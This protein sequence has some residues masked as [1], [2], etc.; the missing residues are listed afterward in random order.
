M[1]IRKFIKQRNVA[2]LPKSVQEIIRNQQDEANSYELAAKEALEKSIAEAAFYVD[3]EHIEMRGGSAVSRINQALEYLV[4]HVYSE[5]GLVEKNAATDADVVEVLNS[6]YLPGAEPN[7]AAAAKV[8]E[9]LDLQQRMNLPTTMFDVQSRYQAAPYGWREIDVAAVVALLINQQKV[10]IKYGGAT[11]RSDDA[12]LPDMLRKKSEIGKTSISI[13]QS[14]KPQQMR[15]AREILREY[16]DVMD[17]PDDEEGLVRFII[18][19]FS[20]QK[21]HYQALEKRYTTGRLYPDKAKVQ[22]AVQLTEDILAQQKDNIALIER[23]LKLEDPLLDSKEELQAVEDFFKNQVQIFDAAVRME[24][25]LRNELDYLSREPAANDA[26]NQIRLIVAVEGGFSYQKIPELN[27]LMAT[28]R[29]GHGRLLE[30]KRAE[31]SDVIAQCMGAVH[32]AAG[33]AA[34]SAKAQDIAARA[35]DYF[36]QKKAQLPAMESLALLDGLIPPLLQYKDQAVESLEVL[37][38]P[39]VDPGNGPAAGPK[40]IIR[41]YNRAVIFPTKTIASAEDVDD[42]VEKM[43]EQL[44]TLL[45]NCDGIQ[46][47]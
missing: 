16:F 25:D 26:L 12:K 7:R 22:K 42:Y 39:P 47:K 9:Y 5:L 24:E 19:R 1:K 33:K 36:S 18:Q 34:A 10:T 35:D 14:S 31:V 44:K 45:Q 38:E 27:S 13:K 23:L 30:A 6:N 41:S 40:K 29:E 28:V 11:I 32:T 3:G 21:E 37:V 43:R 2:Q 20:D 17:V 15:A 8:E 46:L 4:A